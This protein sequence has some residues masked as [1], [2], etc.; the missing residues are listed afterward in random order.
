MDAIGREKSTFPLGFP[1]PLWDVLAHEALDFVD[2][3][4]EPDR[5]GKTTR[6]DHLF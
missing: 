6:F 3:L 5:L 4:F 1:S 2:P